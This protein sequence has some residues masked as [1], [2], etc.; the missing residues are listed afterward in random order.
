MFSGAIGRI[1]GEPDAGGEIALLDHDGQF[2]ARGLYNPHSQIKARLYCWEENT[3]LDAEFWSQRLDRAI[4]W[5]QRLFGQLSEDVACRLVYSEADGLS[6]LIVD[7]YGDW[8]LVQI[9]SLALSQ[10]LELFVE[11]LKEKLKPA[12]IRLRTEKGIRESEGLTLADHLIDGAEP[13]RPLFIEE[14]AIRYGVDIVQGQK[15]GFY[16]DQR[17]NRAAVSRYLDGHR[18]L[19]MFCY[20]GAF[21]LAAVKLGNAAE[22]L[23]ID[24]SESAIS[25]ARENAELNEVG[26]QCRFEKSDAFKAL[27]Q[28]A[29]DGERFDTVILDPPKL[30]RHRSGL[31]KALRGYFSLNR[32][33][34][35][36]LHPGGL[37][38]T[39]SCSS[40]VSRKDFEHMLATVS[41]RANRPLQILESRGQAPDHP[42][43]VH[44]LE[45]NY[46]KC[47]V[48]RVG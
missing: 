29:A 20:S 25:L 34:F 39:C 35:D 37:L 18:V 3:A 13:P 4:E 47:Y 22:V 36:V 16:L 46:L 28:L 42:T 5:R 33:A 23:G 11:L 27:E 41:L 1:D 40:L 26:P 38:V 12:G 14:H 19:D 48:C 45:N 15:T 21:A 30:T 44:C 17:D 32:L 31:N 8:L 6:G 43:S 10:R 9:T 7:R 24:V 2:I